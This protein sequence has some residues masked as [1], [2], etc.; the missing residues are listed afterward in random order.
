[1]SQYINFFVRY[2]DKFVPLYSSSRSTVIYERFHDWIP[3][4]KIIALSSIDINE[5]FSETKEYEREIDEAIQKSRD[6]IQIVSNYNN[7][8]EEKNEVIHDILMSIEEL[9]E[10]KSDISYALDFCIFLKCI[11]AE[12]LQDT[13]QCIY[14]GI[15]IG[16]PTLDDVV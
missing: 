1:M 13:A 4:E 11:I 8:V 7:S 12:R 14:A 16:E 9:E 10:T 15:E 2:E 6:E 5:I 3:Y